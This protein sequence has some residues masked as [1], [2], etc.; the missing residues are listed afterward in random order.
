MGQLKLIVVRF[1]E[2]YVLAFLDAERK[3][4]AKVEIVVRFCENYVLAYLLQPG[5]R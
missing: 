2:N 5:F 4:R 3:A 1:C